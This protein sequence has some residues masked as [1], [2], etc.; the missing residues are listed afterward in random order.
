MLHGTIKQVTL[1][2]FTDASAI[3]YA[4]CAFLRCVEE[5][6]VKVSLVSAKARVAPVQRPTIP[7]LELSGATIGARIASTI[8]ETLNS[9][10]KTY[11]WTDSMTVLGWIT[12]SEP[13]NTFVGNRVR[14]IRELTNV[15]DWRFV[16]GDLNPADLPSRSCDWSQLFR[17]QWWEGPKWLHESPECWPYTEITLPQEALLERRKSVAVNLTIDTN[18]NFGNRFLYFSSYPKIIRMTAWVLRF[19]HNLKANSHKLRKELTFQ[20]IQMAE[21]AVIR[22]IQAEWSCKMQEKYSKTIQF[23]EENK[24]LKVRS[25]FIL[26]EDAEDF[27][28]PTVLPDHSI[29]RRLIE[30]THKTLQHAG[31]QTTLSQIHFIQDIKGNETVDLDIVDA[32]HLRKRIRYLQTLRFQLRQRFQREYLAELIRNPQ[33][34]LKR[35]NLSPGDI[36]LIGSDN[37]K[38]LNWPLGRVIELFKGKDNIEPVVRLRVANGEI[39]RPIQRIYPLEIDSA[40]FTKSVPEKVESATETIDD[41]DHEHIPPEEQSETLR[42]EQSQSVKKTRFGRRIVPVKRLDL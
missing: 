24:I 27:V 7:R 11:F 23:Y 28:R 3:G 17:S 26:G 16:P 39:I 41:V 25:R 40:E 14:E 38:R 1:H 31:V 37:T 33:L 5:D 36:V 22:I 6:E 21:E 20:E 32:R 10:L 2:I 8:L 34:S 12:N 19:C 9:P 4:C 35:H 30:Y 13:W 18:D 42:I 15:E 29:V